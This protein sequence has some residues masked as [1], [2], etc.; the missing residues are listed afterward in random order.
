MYSVKPLDE[1]PNGKSDKDMFSLI[2]SRTQTEY[3]ILKSQV[4]SSVAFEE[5]RIWIT[6]W[7]HKMETVSSQLAFF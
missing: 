5:K 3:D 4:Q 7:R 1:I 2:R 6:W